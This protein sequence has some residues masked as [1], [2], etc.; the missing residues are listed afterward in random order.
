M[1]IYNAGGG[2]N[3]N[4]ICSGKIRWSGTEFN[5][6]HSLAENT[7]LIPK[8]KR[9]K[10]P[11]VLLDCRSSHPPQPLNILIQGPLRP[12]AGSGAEGR[13]SWGC[14]AVPILIPRGFKI[15]RG[16]ALSSR[17]DPRAGPAWGWSWSPGPILT[18]IC[19]SV[20]SSEL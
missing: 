10:I 2:G 13:A 3:S 8:E 14:G 6:I 17:S 11:S 7:S 1:D 16:Q 20:I 9:Y 15:R 5:L 18:R 4:G 12:Q 19:D